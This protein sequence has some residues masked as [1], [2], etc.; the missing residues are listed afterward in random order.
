VSPS[1]TFFCA[2]LSP[3][4]DVGGTDAIETRVR[5]ELEGHA[6]V[7]LEDLAYGWVRLADARVLYYATP[8]VPAGLRDDESPPGVC[9]PVWSELDVPEGLTEQA[10]SDAGRTDYADIRDR[11]RLDLLRRRAVT[12]RRLR[13]LQ[14]P[15]LVFGAVGVLLVTA[16][17]VLN[18]RARLLERRLVAGA[19]AAAAMTAKRDLLLRLARFA[20]PGS[21]LFDLLVVANRY[22]PPGIALSRAEWADGVLVLDGRAGDVRQVNDYV[23]K[24][25]HTGVFGTVAP[26]KIDTSGGKALFRVRLTV[27]RWPKVAPLPPVAAGKAGA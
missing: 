6:P 10:W 5:W 16:G 21:G 17:L 13:R 3:D 22:R 15:L 23:G 2:F 25:R 4:T 12:G 19:P 1:P 18:F 27:A 20:E 14:A 9:I 7:P 8:F 26:A 11:G 24:L